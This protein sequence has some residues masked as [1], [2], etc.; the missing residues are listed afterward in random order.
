M[1]KIAL[2]LMLLVASPVLA[3]PTCQTTMEWLRAMTQ[4]YSERLVFVGVSVDGSALLLLT[5][6]R[7]TGTWTVGIRS[8]FS[9]CVAPRFAGSGFVAPQQGW[10]VMLPEGAL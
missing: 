2:A 4:H 6:N 10:S 7:V 3:Q 5:V 9:P 1:T 8:A